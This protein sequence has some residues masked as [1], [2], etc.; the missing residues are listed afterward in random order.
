MSDNF[1]LKKYLI[2]NKA[3]TNSR[4]LNENEDDTLHPN[5]KKTADLL[6]Q[7]GIPFEMV[8][9]EDVEAELQ[10]GMDV[11]GDTSLQV[12]KLKGK[13]GN[14]YVLEYGYMSIGIDAKELPAGFEDY[15]TT[16]PEEIVKVLKQNFLMTESRKKHS[17]MMN[18]AETLNLHDMDEDTLDELYIKHITNNAI[19][20]EKYLVSKGATPEEAKEIVDEDGVIEGLKGLGVT[21]THIATL[22]VGG[23]YI[24]NYKVYDLSDG[25][26]AVEEDYLGMVTIVPMKAFEDFKKAL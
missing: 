21:M 11:E 7:E 15:H 25:N 6:K 26:V 9:W 12:I 3:T 8:S 4:M 24:D 18:E 23:T 5:I 20:S 2:E 10:R 17:K 19:D 16:S 14:V 1:D 22:E 13:K